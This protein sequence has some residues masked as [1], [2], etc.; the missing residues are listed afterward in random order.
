MGGCCPQEPSVSGPTEDQTRAE[1]GFHP[2]ERPAGAISGVPSQRKPAWGLP[3][4]SLP[5][6]ESPPMEGISGATPDRPEPPVPSAE[7]GAKKTKRKAKKDRGSSAK[8]KAEQ[9]S[10]DTITPQ[11]G[12]TF[13]SQEKQ[14]EP[15]TSL[16]SPAGEQGRAVTAARQK[17]SHPMIVGEGILPTQMAR[18]SLG[19]KYMPKRPDNG[20]KLGKPCEM[21]VNCWDMEF[22][23]C[24]VRMYCLEE[25]AV[26]NLDKNAGTKKENPMPTKEKRALLKF[27]IPTNTFCVRFHHQRSSTAANV[28]Q[29]ALN[30]HYSLPAH[31]IYDGGHTVYSETQ[32]PDVTSQGVEREMEIEDLQGRGTLLLKYRIAEVQTITTDVLRDYITNPRSTSLEMPQDGIRLLDCVFK[33][34]SKRSYVSLG[35]AAVYDKEP[36]KMIMEK[37][38]SIHRGF[39]SSVR[40]QWKVRIN[41]DL[42]YKAFLT[43]GNLADVIY[44]KYGDNACQRSEQI[45][46]DLS[47]IRVETEP[48]YTETK[49]GHRYS[50]KFTVFGISDKPANELMIE[51]RNQ[52]VAEYFEQ[53]HNIRLKYP[54]YPCVK[55]GC[56]VQVC[57]RFC[58]MAVRPGLSGRRMFTGCLFSNATI[59]KALVTSGDDTN[60]PELFDRFGVKISPNPVEVKGRVLP[61][62]KARF[63]GRN[64]VASSRGSWIASSFYSPAK[65]GSQIQWAILSVPHGREDPRRDQAT[66]MAELPKEAGKYN[67]VM[68]AP[69]QCAVIRPMQLTNMLQDMAKKAIDLVVLILYDE[70]SYG[71]IKRQSDL[72]L[73]IRTQCIRGSTLRKRGVFPNLMLK[74]NGKLGG[75]NWIISPLIREGKESLMVFGADVTHPPPKPRQGILKSVA[76]VIGSITPDLMRYAAVVRQQ[77]TTERGNKTTREIIDNLQSMVS[78]LI[79][80]S[81]FAIDLL[82]ILL[83]Q[84]LAELISARRFTNDVNAG[85]YNNTEY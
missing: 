22:G 18:I 54:Y 15:S 50:R 36:A 78:E 8:E 9:E 41:V 28:K 62:P 31:A 32:V 72:I 39:I 25:I 16:I 57:A 19:E 21:I 71:E 58:F 17:K 59:S 75:I 85:T 51:E 64:E 69:I 13:Q 73:G 34:V 11:G 55:V 46:N 49:T 82:L 60:R 33:E 43:P 24:K 65:S 48:Y 67:V 29:Y 40:P 68:E 53:Q 4:I 35:R 10:G 14:P 30:E 37:L 27:V 12:E 56:A 79:K 63:N 47:E 61:T 81:L 5:P 38:L 44:N 76:A 26:Y 70:N 23:S 84:N 6:S 66:V 80:A 52:T 3:S 2:Q 20:G 83:S 1:G 77:A 74:I 42:T 7:A 45:K